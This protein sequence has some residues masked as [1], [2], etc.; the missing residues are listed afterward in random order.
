MSK[1]VQHDKDPCL[2]KGHKR[3]ALAN[4][5]QPFPSKMKSHYE[6]GFLEMDIKKKTNLSWYFPT[7]ASGELAICID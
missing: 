7:A 2:H 4:I 6:L 3:R 5:L 1:Q